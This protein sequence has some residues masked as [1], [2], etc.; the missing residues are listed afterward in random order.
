MSN[1][2]KGFIEVTDIDGIIFTDSKR[3]DFVMYSE[4][5]NQNILIGTQLSNISAISVRS[6][7]L[8]VSRRVNIGGGSNVPAVALEVNTTDSVLLPKGTTAQRP[9][10]PVQGYVRYNTDINTFEGY[11]AGNAWGSLGGVKD[12]NQDTYIS[13]ESFPTSNDDNLV[14]YNSNIERMRI[15]RQGFVGINTSNPQYLLDVNG[16][17]YFGEDLILNSN[18][19]VNKSIIIQGLRVRKNTGGQVNFSPI[20]VPGV[21]NDSFGNLQIYS[22]NTLINQGIIFYTGFSNEVGRF[23]GDGKFSVGKSNPSAQVH[24]NTPVHND[25]LAVYSTSNINVVEIGDAAPNTSATD[26]TLSLYNNSTKNVYLRAGGVS[27]IKGGNVGIGTMTPS[28]AFD[29]NGDIGITN[30]TIPMGLMTEIGGTTPL[31]NMSVNFREPNKTNNYRG[32]GFRI[33]TRGGIG[34]PI[35]QWISRMA[36]SNQSQENVTMS[37]TETGYLGLGTVTPATIMEIVGTDALLVPKGTTA[38]RPETTKQGQI[39]YNTDTNTFEGYGSGNTWGSLGGIKDTNQDTYISAE[40]FPTSNDDII[41]FYNSNVET[42]RITKNGLLGIGTTSPS[43]KLDVT[44]STRIT[45]SLISSNVTSGHFVGYPP[46]ATALSPVIGWPFQYLDSTLGATGG[47]SLIWGYSTGTGNCG[48]LNFSRNNGDAKVS[49]GFYGQQHLNILSSSGNVGIGTT[50]PSYKLHVAG[51]ICTNLNNIQFQPSGGSITSDGTYGIYWN[52]GSGTTADTNYAIYRSSGAW[53][54]NNYQQLVLSW[55][56]GI[57]MNPGSAYGKSYV[58][59]QGGGLRVTSGNVGI[60]T[61]TPGYKLEVSGAIYASGDITALSDK[62]FKDDLQP[63]TNACDTVSKLQGFSYIRKDYEK[64]EEE[65]GTRHIGLIAQDVQE[66]LPE[67]VSYDK[68]NDKYGINYGSMTGVFVEAIK[69][70]KTKVDSLEAIVEK[71]NMIIQQLLGK[72]SS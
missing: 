33:D 50:A 3:N 4:A 37:L 1:D 9:S 13:A 34:F 32:A 67:V 20:S 59:I 35:F 31:L 7:N 26:G 52:N 17:G 19:F 47:N 61:T 15:T 69:E 8:H 65:K 16:K 46:G 27:Y 57:I 44:G 24:F 12:T 6:N 29:V 30:A 51:A 66:V 68:T 21:S 55:T 11:G 72:F 5:S 54:S 38:Q 63:I 49:V 42:M 14:F 18:L 58:D 36:T 39:R 48:E 62:R 10:A 22:Q 23:T 43:Y 64:M 71:Q 60:G 56:T 2:R 25:L 45:G 70:L 40:S 28:N 53:I 41:R